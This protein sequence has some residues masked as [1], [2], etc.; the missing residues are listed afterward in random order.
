MYREKCHDFNLVISRKQSKNQGKALTLT[1][2]MNHK[3][4]HDFSLVISR[5]LSYC[6]EKMKLILNRYGSLSEPP[7]MM[8]CL[9]NDL[10]WF[11]PEYPQFLR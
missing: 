9:V 4:Y 5:K 6:N 3:R 8:E 7:Q 2:P 11:V 1:D 10:Y